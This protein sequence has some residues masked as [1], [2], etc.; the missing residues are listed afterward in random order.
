MDARNEGL[1]S[2][3]TSAADVRLSLLKCPPRLRIRGETSP[4]APQ[5]R[6]RA[7]LHNVVEKYAGSPGDGKPAPLANS[8]DTRKREGE[9]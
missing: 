8:I 1:Y 3:K 2:T 7:T 5:V 4:E 9:R 6:R